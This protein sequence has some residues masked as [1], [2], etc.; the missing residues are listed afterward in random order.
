MS[1]CLAIVNIKDRAKI[2][3]QIKEKHPAGLYLCLTT[4]MWERFSVKIQTEM[5]K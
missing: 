5:R 1:S 2:Y 3:M 4:V